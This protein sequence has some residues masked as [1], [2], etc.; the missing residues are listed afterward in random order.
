MWAM[1]Y[2]VDG[3]RAAVGDR[4][5]PLVSAEGKHVV[6]IGGGDTGADCV[7]T[8]H[9]QNPRSVT[10][11]QIN[12]RPP[13]EPDPSTPWPTWPLVMRSAPAYEEGGERVFAMSTVELVGD[14]DGRVRGVVLEE[15]RKLGF[16]S[17][18]P[19]RGTREEI[20]ADLVLL[21]LGFDGPQ[22]AGFLEQLG[23]DFDA[24]GNVVRDAR[25]RTSVPRVFVAGDAGR[26]QSLVV[27]AIAEG[28]ACAAEVDRML[29]GETTLPFPMEATAQPLSA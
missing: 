3:N 14:A 17:Y 28:R 1:D 18:E 8:A 12:P 5:A 19:V 13:D 10:Q 9:R 15:V 25:Y 20:P 27:W 2:L 4:P 7:G 29:T 11:L 16:R 23:V 6:V 21:A 24:R 26:G 22:R